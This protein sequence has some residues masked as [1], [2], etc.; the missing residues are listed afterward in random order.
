M[1]LAKSKFT[2]KKKV[3]LELRSPTREDAQAMLDYLRQLHHESWF[4]MNSRI[5][6][7]DHAPLATEV[8]IVEK[9]EQNNRGFFLSAFRDQRIVGN[10][11]LYPNDAQLKLHC[12][13]VAMGNLKEFQ[14][15]GLGKEL[16]CRCCEAALTIGLWNLQLTVRAHNE[17]GIRL[18]EK[19]G[20][21]RVGTWKEFALIDGKFVDEHIYQRIVRV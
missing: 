14:G 19:C 21:Q 10:V 15:C 2:T 20:F 7:Y 13:E 18:Y 4:N 1:L 12:G 3:E 11:A 6:R 9:M 16:L 17:A 8:E 5:D